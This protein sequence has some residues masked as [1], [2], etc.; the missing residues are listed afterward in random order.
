[1]LHTLCLTTRLSTNPY[2]P[3][4]PLYI[5]F[6]NSDHLHNIRYL[7]SLNIIDKDVPP[8]KLPSPDTV[9]HI[10]TTINFLKS[11]NISDSNLPRLAFLCPQLFTTNVDLSE[12]SPVFDFL[13]SE[14]H[15]STEQSSGLI[16]NCPNILFSDVDYCLR[17]TLN[18]LTTL[19]LS[20]EKLSAPS[21][22]NAHLLNTRVEKLRRHVR[23]LKKIGLSHEEAKVICVRLPAVFGYSIDNNLLPKFEF[24]VYEM[25]RSLEELKGFP[26]YFGFSLRKRIA[27]RHFHLKERNV[28]KIKLNRMLLWSDN[29]FYAKWK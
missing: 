7:K 18:Y 13:T 23:F 27:P 24:L 22:I 2:P 10:L 9:D 5:K 3:P 17:P 12:I 1:M 11:K 16:V 28:N 6:K 4:P 15:A 8:R 25:E 21:K 29:K 20:L 26:Q 14:L 19:G